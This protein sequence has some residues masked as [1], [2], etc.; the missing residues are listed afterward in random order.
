[1]TTSPSARSCTSIR[2]CERWSIARRLSA[3]RSSASPAASAVAAVAAALVA[4]CSPSSRQRD[5]LG[6]PAVGQ[7]EGRARPRSSTCDV[8]RA[9]RRRPPRDRTSRTRACVRSAIAA[10]S[11]SSALSTARAVAA[12][13]LDELALGHAR[14]C[15]WRAELADVGLADV[16]HQRDVGRRDLTAAR[17]GGRCRARPSP[18]PGSG[19]R[20]SARSTVSG[21]PSSLLKEP[22]VATV[23]ARVGEHPGQHV[24]GRGLALRAG[25]RRRPRRPGRAPTAGA[26]PAR[27]SSCRAACT[28]STSTV[29]TP[30]AGVPSTPAAPPSTA[31]AA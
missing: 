10:T 7:V 28:S 31:A 17:R 13:R 16:E 19:S 25:D 4:W 20:P 5:V 8:R 9:G 3:I 1:M 21:R 18:A 30:V 26:A 2:H 22:A 29:G 6:R 24:L 27:A 23:G 12:Q 11:G 14:S 15:S